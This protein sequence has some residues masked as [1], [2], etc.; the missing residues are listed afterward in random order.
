MS[1]NF[2]PHRLL[3]ALLLAAGG[4]G[5]DA[6]L[7]ER[8]PPAPTPGEK[9]PPAE[10]KKV[11]VGPNVY[12][13]VQGARRRVL[14]SAE[15]CLREGALELFLC[16]KNTKEHEAVVHAE[17]DARDIHQA[18]LL[19][20]AEPGS[21]VKF[22]P[23]Y[24][25]AKGQPIRVSV[26]YEEKGKVR[27]VNARSWVKNAK[28]GK[29]LETDWVFAG[30]HLVEN[31]LDKNKPKVYMAQDSGDVIC[32]SNFE[33]AMLDVPILSSKDDADRAFEAFTARIPEVGTKVSVILE[34]LPA[35]KKSK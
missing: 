35:P 30:S 16:R 13:E 5:C 29:E 17:A 3:A 12:L 22:D 32:V 21:P 19:A 20:E 11:R 14:I 34:P 1:A 24:T 23:K 9:A 15:V 7:S 2:L 4:V 6:G 31:L 28:T 33:T 18:L 8:E 25:P 26:E 27:H 10:A